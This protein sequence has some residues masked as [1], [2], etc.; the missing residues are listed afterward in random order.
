MTHTPTFP[1]RRR[2][3]AIASITAAW[4]GLSMDRARAQPA[5]AASAEKD[6]PSPCSNCVADI[7]WPPSTSA[8]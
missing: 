5:P 8:I 7:V 2:F 4:W 6:T 1:L 3:L